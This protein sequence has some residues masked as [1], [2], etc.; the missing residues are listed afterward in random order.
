M[1]MANSTRGMND[2]ENRTLAATLRRC[3]GQICRPLGVSRGNEERAMQLG[4]LRF[5]EWPSGYYEI[6]DAGRNL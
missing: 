2:I 1:A 3:K 4:Y 5:H 6:T